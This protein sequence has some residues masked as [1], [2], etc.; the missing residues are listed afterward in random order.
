MGLLCVVSDAEGL[1][2]NVLHGKTG[3]VVPKRSPLLLAA[4]I[5]K[6]ARLDALKAMNIRSTAVKRVRETFNLEQQQEAFVGF[7][8]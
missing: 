3:W 7:Y 4:Q 5:Q 2:E 1:T 8:L 6:V